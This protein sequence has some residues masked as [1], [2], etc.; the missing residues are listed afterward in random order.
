VNIVL[1]ISVAGGMRCILEGDLTPRLPV[2]AL[3]FRWGWWVKNEDEGLA[4]V[5]LTLPTAATERRR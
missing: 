2:A 5:C 1:F 3:T 4:D